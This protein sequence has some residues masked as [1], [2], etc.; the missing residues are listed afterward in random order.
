M[1]THVII[2]ARNGKVFS[3]SDAPGEGTVFFA[4]DLISDSWHDFSYFLEASILHEREGHLTQRN[5]HVRA[6]LGNLFSHLDGVVSEVAE[7]LVKEGKIERRF[8]D[9][10]GGKV[11]SLKAKIVAIRNH[12][13]KIRK[14]LPFLNLDLKPIR[15]I[16]N[17]PS[18]VKP[19]RPEG[20]NV[21]VISHVDTYGLDIQDLIEASKQIDAW[22]N[23]LCNLSGYTRFV[24]TE[25]EVKKL[26]SAL[27]FPSSEV[28][29]F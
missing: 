26:V 7:R 8:S 13:R 2:D 12:Y 3:S 19:S 22:L 5:R 9:G 24:N 18:A 15:D 21:A 14:Q 4:V 25:E 11:C 27:G 10:Q 29:G 17:H 6:A 1:A 23:K 16:I 20:G 28:S